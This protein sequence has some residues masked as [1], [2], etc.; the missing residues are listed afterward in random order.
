MES[1]KPM[2]ETSYQTRKTRICSQDSRKDR[3]EKSCKKSSTSRSKESMGEKGETRNYHRDSNR[4]SFIRTWIGTMTNVIEY[5]QRRKLCKEYIDKNCKVT[6]DS[7]IV[8][9]YSL[10]GV[11]G[12]QERFIEPKDGIKSKTVPWSRWFRFINTPR[13]KT[14][15]ILITE[16]EIDFLSIIPYAKEYNVMWIKGIG[17]LPNA[18]REI[19]TLKKTY[20]VYILVD[21]DEPADVSISRIAYTEL[22]LYDV[23]NALN[24]CKDVNEAIIQGKLNMQAIPKR[25]IKVKPQ[26]KIIKRWDNLDTIEKI[27]EIPAIDVLET[28]FPEYKRHGLE[29]IYEQWKET[30]GYKYSK[31]LNMVT[32]FSWKGRPSWTTRMIAKAKFQDPHL[33]FLYFKWKI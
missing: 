1:K 4:C 22:H 29:S 33:T 31:R 3:E 24:G 18:I 9:I 32:D 19:E 28:L 7:I 10:N 15:D 13:D 23:R 25:I 12:W 11:T 20:D 16:W 27:N 30:H 21:N 2:R 5:I 6:N 26:P 17:N 14:K 8:P